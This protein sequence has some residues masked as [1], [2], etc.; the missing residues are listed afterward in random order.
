MTTVLSQRAKRRFSPPQPLDRH[1]SE[2]VQ[3]DGKTYINAGIDST[4]FVSLV[5]RRTSLILFLQL[6]E[7]NLN[8]D[9]DDEG[10]HRTEIH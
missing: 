6:Q 3:P 8:D 4:W 2:L 5:A 9:A 10:I 1:P 7:R